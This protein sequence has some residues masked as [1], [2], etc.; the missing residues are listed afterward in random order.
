MSENSS[1]NITS[2]SDKVYMKTIYFK[3]LSVYCVK[4]ALLTMNYVPDP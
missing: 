2:K 3:Y 1:R 4:N